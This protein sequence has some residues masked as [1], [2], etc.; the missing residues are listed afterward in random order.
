MSDGSPEEIGTRL[1]L[2]SSLSEMCIDHFPDIG[3]LVVWTGNVDAV[4]DNSVLKAD[5]SDLDMGPVDHPS[6]AWHACRPAW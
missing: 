1:H 4:A 5:D 2:R 3:L 6:P